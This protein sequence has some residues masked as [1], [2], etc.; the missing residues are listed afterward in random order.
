MKPPSGYPTNTILDR[1]DSEG[2]DALRRRWSEQTYRRSMVVVSAGDQRNNVFFILEGKVRLM[3]FSRTGRE[4]PFADL[5]PGSTFGETSA[6]LELPRPSSVSTLTGCRLARI[7]GAQ[8]REILTEQPSLMMA[9]MTHLASRLR[10]LELRMLDLT[11]LNARERLITELL[12]RARPDGRGTDVA[13][14]D[15]LPTQQ[16]LANLICSQ[17][18]T[19]GRDLS[20]LRSKGLLR[21]DGGRRLVIESVEGLRAERRQHGD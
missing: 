7:S 5:G 9:M 21:T 8:F 15:D 1:C 6:L 10:E 18:E 2:L 19:V 13:V 3:A 20:R 11:S 16:E 17:R 14:I 12:A 4:V